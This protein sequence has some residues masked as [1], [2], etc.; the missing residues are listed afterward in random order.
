M[1]EISENLGPDARVPWCQNN[2][3]SGLQTQMPTGNM[4]VKEVGGWAE[5]KN[6]NSTTS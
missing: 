2:T 4:E 5:Y 6:S 1:S 3:V